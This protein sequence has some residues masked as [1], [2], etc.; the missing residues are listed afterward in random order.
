MAEYRRRYGEE[1]PPT[2]WPT[3]EGWKAWV[4]SAMQVVGRIGARERR[5]RTMDA[6]EAREHAVCVCACVCLYA[7]FR[8][9]T[10]LPVHVRVWHVS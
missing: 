5:R 10:M 8:G 2:E 3:S 1:W 7:S 9:V 6:V 4:R